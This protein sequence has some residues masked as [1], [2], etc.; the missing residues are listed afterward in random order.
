MTVSVIVMKKK[1]RGRGR[2]EKGRSAL[3]K[4]RSTPPLPEPLQHARLAA[5]SVSAAPVQCRSA[6]QSDGTDACTDESPPPTRRARRLRRRSN[7]LSSYTQTIHRRSAPALVLDA[8]TRV[9]V[10]AGSK[11]EAASS[12]CTYMVLHKQSLCSCAAVA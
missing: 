3:R 9:A 2:V 1:G 8:S 11:Q 4:R 12:M 5:S 7:T 6:L 10:A